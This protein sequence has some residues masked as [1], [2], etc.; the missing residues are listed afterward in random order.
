ME[1][2]EPSEAWI[3]RVEAEAAAAGKRRIVVV[4]TD[5]Q[6][7]WS[8][9]GRGQPEATLDEFAEWLLD[10]PDS[11]LLFNEESSWAIEL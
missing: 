6:G 9:H 4:L 2:V 10:R 1:A 7:G 3:D 11:V 8:I 5:G